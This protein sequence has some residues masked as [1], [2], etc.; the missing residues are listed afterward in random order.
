MSK[1]IRF[2]VKYGY[3][4]REHVSVAVGAELDRVIYAWLEQVPVNLG[5]RLIHGKQILSIE[6]DYHYYTGWFPQYEPTSAED[7]Q[8]IQRDCPLF[9]GYIEE[10]TKR[11]QQHIETNQTHLIGQTAQESYP[12]IAND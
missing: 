5:D 9:A 10:T 11:V 7:W 4:P 6:P 1:Q 3:K 12:Q 8:Q 2:K